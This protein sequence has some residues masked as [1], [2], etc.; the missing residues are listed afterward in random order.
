MSHFDA[1]RMSSREQGVPS[2]RYDRLR[3][4]MFPEIEKKGQKSPFLG[5]K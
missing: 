3:V 5:R 2:F 4:K 1:L